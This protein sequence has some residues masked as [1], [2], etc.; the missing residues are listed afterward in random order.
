MLTMETMVEKILEADGITREMIQ[1]QQNRLNLLQRLLSTAPEGR[2]AIIQQEEGQITAD[3]FALLNRLIESTAAQGDQEAAQQLLALQQQL[4]NETKAGQELQ[5][6]V[7]ETEE[8]VKSLQEASQKGLTREAL[9]GFDHQRPHRNPPDH[10]GQP[11]PQRPGLYFFQ[12]LSDRIESASSEEKDKM[13]DLRTKLLEMT[14]EIDQAVQE[15]MKEALQ[16]LNQL[17]DAPDIEQAIT[18]NPG[19]VNDFF[20]D[21]L[22]SEFKAATEK[23]DAQRRDKLQKVIQ[24]IEK[25]SAPPPEVEFIK[26]L[27]AAEDA[28][29]RQQ[30]F[31][32]QRKDYSQIH[33]LLNGLVAQK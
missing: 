2:L 6:Q 8:A 13:N 15:Q 11:G 26:Q 4:L 24:T 3:F 33:W 16:A 31:S 20:I 17:L 23:G 21:V 5:E 18:E 22:H 30:L 28:Q 29:A 25:L 9:L 14:R 27:L 19:L 32:Q 1:E 7:K 12:L 10:A